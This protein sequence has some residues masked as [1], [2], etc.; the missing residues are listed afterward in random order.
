MEYIMGDYVPDDIKEQFLIATRESHTR[1]QEK[2]Q[3]LDST[4]RSLVTRASGLVNDR[5]ETLH[6]YGKVL[7]ALNIQ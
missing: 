1:N 4:I 5:V 7:S 6:G 3:N 2:V